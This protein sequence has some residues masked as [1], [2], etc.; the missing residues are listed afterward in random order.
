MNLKIFFILI[1]PC[2]ALPA[3]NIAKL[4]VKISQ[5]YADGVRTEFRCVSQKNWNIAPTCFFKIIDKQ[6]NK[7]FAIDTNINGYI[8]NFYYSPWDYHFYG[9]LKGNHFN[10]VMDVE[11]SEEDADVVGKIKNPTCQISFGESSGKLTAS[12][13]IISYFDGNDFQSKTRPLPYRN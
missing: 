1:T 4:P 11:C 6:K 13:V 5:I 10:M 12:E 7:E 3:A 9:E 8:L 2:V